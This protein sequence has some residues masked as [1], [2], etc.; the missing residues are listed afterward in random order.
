MPDTFY[1]TTKCVRKCRSLVDDLQFSGSKHAKSVFSKVISLRNHLAHARSVLEFGESPADV[2]NRIRSL[3]SLAANVRQLLLNRDAVWDS[4]AGTV[5]AG[6]ENSSIV[7][8]GSGAK[9]LPMVA[10][11]HVISAQN[12]YEKFLG[13][14]ENL[15]RTEILGQYLQATPGVVAMEQVIGRASDSDATW[16]EESWAVSGLVR[17]QALDI[18]KYFQQRAIF[19]LTESDMIVVAADGSPVIVLPRRS[20]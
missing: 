15:R 2:L 20:D 5:I 19:E 18:A 10:P 12:P 13:E 17:S 1:T 4:Y 16:K 14:S 8:A 6:G 9:S 7:F 11:V 3:E